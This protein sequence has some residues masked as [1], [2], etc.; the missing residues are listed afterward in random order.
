MGRSLKYEV[1][2]EDPR[3]SMTAVAESGW[4]ACFARPARAEA[5]SASANAVEPSGVAL[6]R[7]VLEIGF[8]RGEFLLEMAARRPEIAFVGI[9]VSFKRALKMAR[10]VGRAGLR[11][12]RLLEGR[13]EV[14]LR[15]LFEPGQLAEIWINFSDPW[16][17]GRHAHRRLIQPPVVAVAADRLAEGGTLYVATD[18]VPYAHQIDE[19]LSGESALRNRYW[20]WPFLPEIEGRMKTGYELQWRAEGRPLHFFAYDRAV[21]CE[22]GQNRSAES[23]FAGFE[24]R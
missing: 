21:Q 14:G 24:S 15:Q 2:G 13:A 19:V 4:A 7:M 16:P 11:N 20:P 6:D 18:D 3:V 12:V 23:G 5:V 9:E 22:P 8:G 17:K 10:K 1:P